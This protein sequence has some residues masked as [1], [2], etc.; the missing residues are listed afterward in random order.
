MLF[1]YKL[2]YFNNDKFFSC[3]SHFEYYQLSCDLSCHILWVLARK[4]ISYLVTSGG[5]TISYHFVW[6]LV[7]VLVMQAFSVLHHNGNIMMMMMMGWSFTHCANSADNVS[8]V[9]L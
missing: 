7:I 2:I 5:D 8:S 6:F 9:Y 4:D 3:G 1:P